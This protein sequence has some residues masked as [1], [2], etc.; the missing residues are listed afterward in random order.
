M[1]CKQCEDI[2]LNYNLEDIPENIKKQIDHHRNTCIRCAQLWE[3]N[4]LINRA[5]QELRE[6]NIDEERIPH[7]H[8]K[9]MNRV[10]QEIFRQSAHVNYFRVPP[11][12]WQS[13]ATAAAALVLGI[14]LGNFVPGKPKPATP[15]LPI[16]SVNFDELLKDNTLNDIRIHEVNQTTGEL[17]ISASKTNDL[18]LTGNITDPEIQKV[19]AYA[20]VRDQNP[21]TRLRSVKLMEGVTTSNAVQQALITSVLQDENQGVRQRALRALAQYPINDD[22]RSTYLNIISNDPSPALRIEAIQILMRDEDD[23]TRSAVL[24]A[25]E[26]ESNEMIQDIL[27]RYYQEPGLPLEKQ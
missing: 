20:L 2:L 14:V 27:K 5:M 7:V 16:A 1:K 17:I 26:E 3:D 12:F 19:L 10:Q 4:L 15:D 25:S 24:N 22:L 6:V 11:R 18:T 21:G 9:I 23:A 13:A 8:S